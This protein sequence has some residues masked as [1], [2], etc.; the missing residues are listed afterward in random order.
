[1]WTLI[2]ASHWNYIVQE[3]LTSCYKLQHSKEHCCSQWLKHVQCPSLVNMSVIR[4]PERCKYCYSAGSLHVLD[5]NKEHISGDDLSIIWFR[6]CQKQTNKN[7]TFCSP[8]KP[9]STYK[10]RI[11]KRTTKHKKTMLFDNNKKGNL[12]GLES[13]CPVT[14]HQ[15]GSIP[16][17]FSSSWLLLYLRH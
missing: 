13:F 14:V 1:M 11:I 7:N 8:A 9:I 5:S 12:H 3:I 6:N 4:P 16:S 15:A 10:K 2:H 17:P